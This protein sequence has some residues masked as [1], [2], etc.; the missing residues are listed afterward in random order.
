[1]SDIFYVYGGTAYANLT[2][3]CPCRCTF[4]IR[5]NGESVGNAT[6][7][8]LNSD[9]TMDDILAALKEFPLSNF[10]ELVFCGYGE[11]TCAVE[12]LT[13]TA[14]YVKE[15]YNVK[16]RL[17]TNGLGNM[18]NGRDILPEIAPYLDAISISLNS[19]TAE[20]YDELCRPKYEG[21]FDEM[22]RFAKSCKGVIPEITLS[23]VDV[24]SDDDIESCRKIAED[25]GIHYRVRVKD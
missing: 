2:N 15:H 22:L 25:L 11:P 9:P 20:K 13:A 19:P 3:K 18:I 21:A 4:C 6:S 17:N 7:L 24:I 16:T 10:D 14:K 1:M 8:W 12:N 5:Q 23:V